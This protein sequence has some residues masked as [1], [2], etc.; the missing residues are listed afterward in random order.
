MEY[1]P[2]FLDIE[3]KTVLICGNGRH[4]LEKIRRLKPYQPKIVVITPAPTAELTA[5][6]GI[7][8]EA[9][10]FSE[11]DLDCHPAFVVTGENFEE[12]RRI[13]QICRE[14]R[15]PVNAVDQQSDCDFLFPALLKAGPLSVGISTSGASPTA[16]MELR[17]QFRELVPARIEE[18]LD[19]LVPARARIFR[20]VEDKKLQRTILRTVV[21]KAFTLDR[22]L[23]AGEL[24]AI[25]FEKSK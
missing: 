14:H 22:P 20:Q 11:A 25:L 10:R 21:Q 18:I 13:S 1:F 24:S 6:E 8:M 4:A 16:A 23:T 3:N 15:V 2:L 5:M 12:N 19:W 17:D 9:H 7:T